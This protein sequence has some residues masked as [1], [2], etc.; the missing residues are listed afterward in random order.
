MVERIVRFVELQL[1]LQLWSLKFHRQDP[2]KTIGILSK[3]KFTIKCI[4]LLP[5]ISAFANSLDYL[6]YVLVPLLE[7]ISK[8]DGNI[9]AKT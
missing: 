2:P 5:H 3:T 8:N 4:S 9:E 7:G 1:P 6:Q